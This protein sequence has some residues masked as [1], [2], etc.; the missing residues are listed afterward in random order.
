MMTLP[1]LIPALMKSQPHSGQASNPP[2][3]NLLYCSICGGDFHGRTSQLRVR[4]T[5]IRVGVLGAGA[6]LRGLLAYVLGCLE[7]VHP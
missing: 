2:F 4:V 1:L 3:L 6:P 5:V 7:Q